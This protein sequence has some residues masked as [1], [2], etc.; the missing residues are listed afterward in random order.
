MPGWLSADSVV[1]LSQALEGNYYDWNPIAMSLWWSITNAVAGPSFLL[2][3]QLALYW[4][5]W[6]YLA[7]AF[8]FRFPKN[9]H[10]IS[11]IG[12]FP[13]FITTFGHIWKDNQFA[14][15]AFLVTCLALSKHLNK[16]RIT[17]WQFAFSLLLL[18][19]AYGVKPNGL[20]VVLL[21]TCWLVTLRLGWSSKFCWLKF[22]AIMASAGLFLFAAG[23]VSALLVQPTKEYSYQYFM[24]H[25][26][27]GIA[28]LTGIDARPEYASELITLEEFSESYIPDNANF[29][30]FGRGAGNLKTSDYSHIQQIE[31]KWFQAVTT[32]PNEYLRHRIM[33]FESLLRL[34]YESPAFVANGWSDKNNFGFSNLESPAAA[35]LIGTIAAL[36][37]FFFPWIIF[38]TGAAFG[39]LG[40]YRKSHRGVVLFIGAVSLAFV[41]PHFL[42]APASDYRYLLFAYL[43]TPVLI[44]LAC[45]A[46]KNIL[47]KSNSGKSTSC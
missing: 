14:S 42:V 38:L 46:D 7:N 41:L 34:G 19:Y 10:L 3:Q 28:H 20:A 45:S 22:P 25:D 29:L 30:F 26:L 27:Q 35:L 21:L 24:M 32:H 33:V 36:P 11:L 44:L 17:N 9:Y 43:L 2:L 8:R 4:L 18:A 12:F 23:S 37:W 5:G 6:G 1:Q 40:I 31:D 39:G 13:S 15:A 47:V 16:Q